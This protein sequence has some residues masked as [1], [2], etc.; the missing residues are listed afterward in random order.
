MQRL[1]LNGTWRL[2]QAG[3][4]WSLPAT[5][6]GSV[7]ADLLDNQKIDDPFWRT[8][9]YAARDLFWNDYL[10]EREFE[11]NN[12]VLGSQMVELVCY[13]LDTIAD[14]RING[15]LLAQT[16]DMHRTYRW[17]V[18][19]LLHEGTNHISVYFHSPL[20]YISEQY[21][22]GDIHYT[23][24]GSLPGNGF[25]RKG[26][27][28]F[29]WDWGPQLPDAGIWR[30]I[31][32][33][34]ARGAVLDDV[35]VVQKHEQGKV[36]VTA[37]VALRRFDNSSCGV[38]LTLTG[39]DGSC[40]TCAGIQE[41]SGSYTF[42][43]EKPQ[44]WWPNGW[45]EQPLY[46]LSVV[47]KSEENVLD[48]KALTIGLR[49]I[50]VSTQKDQWGSEF[51]FVVN[52]IK[53]FAMGANYI[54]EDNILRRVTPQRTERLIRDCARANFNCLRVWGGG[55]YP[56]DFFY[57]LCDRYGIMVWQDLMFACNVYGL[58]DAFEA[59]IVAETRDN[60]RRIRHHASL[61]LWCGNNEMEWGWG[62]PWARIQGHS[63]RYTADYI[64]IFEYILPRTVRREDPQ[65]FYWLSSP[66]SG[67]ALDDPNNVDRGDTHYWEVWHS[68]KPFTEYRQ[69]YFRFCSE[70]GFQSFPS[71]KTL[72]S[73]C[74]PEDENIFSEVMES[75]QKNGQANGKIF[76]YVAGYFRY[77]KDLEN[78]AY[79][80][81]V[82]QLKAIQYGVEHWRRNRGRCMGS[83]YWQLNDC[84]PVASWASID[85]LGRWKALHYGAKRFYRPFMASACEQEELSPHISYYVHNDTLQPQS[86][87]LR[88]TLLH[89]DFTVLWQKEFSAF[90]PPLS[91]NKLYDA[92]F[93]GWFAQYD[94]RELVAQYELVQ[95]DEVISRGVTLFVKPKHFHLE[96]P[97]YRCRV[98]EA[99]DCFLVT[100][101]SNTFAHYVELDLEGADAVFSDNYF[102]ITS[103]QGYTVTVAK[104]DLSAPMTAAQLEQKLTVKSVAD[105]YE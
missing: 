43:V 52:G 3:Q 32:L 6:P 65:T 11:V 56:D 23:A 71:I 84:W 66:S 2:S 39:P 59:N 86:A 72:R 10:Y 16:D 76:S 29:G 102:D 78:I 24:T 55:Y 36:W 17:P 75:H 20:Q 7:L 98:E 37:E 18:G 41:D 27:S 14:I 31:E 97:V 34:Y 105:S 74:L 48:S 61:A 94:K 13:G 35:R 79:I 47:L 53:I 22:K 12:T 26:H 82:L 80:S 83:L 9:E 101:S 88:V 25:L 19:Q 77:P 90:V 50:T 104:N 46:E 92:D 69:S 73:F 62:E 1:S 95:Q 58:T 99:D 68:N 8:N 49:T 63:P 21:A 89:R 57:D 54:P 15:T 67:G 44:L 91:V 4:D 30:G 81:Q 5:V 103:S 51:A 45:G 100:V 96:K 28:M 42:C 38:E 40:Q 64:K 70:Y 93:S 87:T 33:Q 60:V 85:S